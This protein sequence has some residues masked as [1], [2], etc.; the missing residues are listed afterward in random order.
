MITYKAHKDELNVRLLEELRLELLD[1]FAESMD[2]ILSPPDGLPSRGDPCSSV[3]MMLRRE[4]RSVV[5][6]EGP[7]SR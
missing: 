3:P 2:F 1:V 5:E 6:R 4:E 7:E